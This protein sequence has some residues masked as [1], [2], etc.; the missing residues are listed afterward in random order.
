MKNQVRNKK[1]PSFGRT[2]AANGKYFPRGKKCLT[3]G[4]SDGKIIMSFFVGLCA[5]A[6]PTPVVDRERLTNEKPRKTHTHTAPWAHGHIL[7]HN[8]RHAHAGNTAGGGDH[9][10]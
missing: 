4:L 10:I 8:T 6:F 9:H 7:Y 5:D 1:I 3:A 2:A